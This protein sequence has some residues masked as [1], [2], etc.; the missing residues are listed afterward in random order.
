MGPAAAVHALC[1]DEQEQVYDGAVNGVRVKPMVNSGADNDH[2]AALCINRILREFA[3]DFDHQFP[4]DAGNFFLPSRCKRHASSNVRA[5]VPADA[6]VDAVVGEGQVIN[7][8]HIKDFLAIFFNFFDRNGPSSTFL[9]S[10][11]K[12]G[13]FTV[14][15]SSSVPSKESRGFRSFPVSSSTMCKFHFPFR[16]SGSPSYRG[17]W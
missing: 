10:W 14:P 9:P 1:P 16:P 12:Y 13:I 4:F 6:A 11:E 7:G 8:G 3:G 5:A 15:I 17:G 2:R